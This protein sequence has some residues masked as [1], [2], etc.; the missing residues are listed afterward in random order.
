[1]CRNMRP[2]IIPNFKG[3][4]PKNLGTLNCNK[5]WCLA[6]TEH[7]KYSL[8]TW[9]V[10]AETLTLQVR[11]SRGETLSQ[12]A[13]SDNSLAGY[14]SPDRSPVARGRPCVPWKKT[15]TVSKH[16][17]SPTSKFHKIQTYITCKIQHLNE[18]DFTLSPSIELNPF[19]EG[20][21]SILI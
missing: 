5:I 14:L 20:M 6:P 17:K 4:V 13:P 10:S 19:E 15:A 21:I 2:N 16:H 7:M 12:E 18:V 11:L 8:Q 9:F 1:M 3:D